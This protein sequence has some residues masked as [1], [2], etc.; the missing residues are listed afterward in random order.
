MVLLGPW[1][2]G[3]GSLCPIAKFEIQDYGPGP[4][5]HKAPRLGPRAVSIS[6]VNSFGDNFVWMYISVHASISS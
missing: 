5:N 2:N 1:T 3:R 4:P 6:L